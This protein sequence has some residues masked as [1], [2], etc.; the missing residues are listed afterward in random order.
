MAIS[1][2]PKGIHMD[3]ALL[4][5]HLYCKK[6]AESDSLPPTKA[7][8]LQHVKRSHMQ[9]FIWYQ[10]DIAEQIQPDPTENGWY[11]DAGILKCI[12][13]DEKPAPK[14]IMELVYCNCKN[15]LTV[16]QADVHVKMQNLCALNC[17]IA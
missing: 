12:T 2:A 10:C 15:K 16:S 4:R 13:A 14:A 9:A 1:Y 8:L 5:W 11:L 6:M 3:L 17:A 7:S